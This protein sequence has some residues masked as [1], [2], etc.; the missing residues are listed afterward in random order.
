MVAAPGRLAEVAIALGP[1][2]DL[3]R[4]TLYRD[5]EG[6][7]PLP[8]VGRGAVAAMPDLAGRVVLEAALR[9]QRRQRRLQVLGVLCVDMAAY[10]CREL[11]VHG[12]CSTIVDI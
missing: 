12:S 10:E 3:P 9:V 8:V 5:I 4:F 1:G 7:P 6:G 11:W 2:G